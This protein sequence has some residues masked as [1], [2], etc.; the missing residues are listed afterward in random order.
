MTYLK[1]KPFV[2]LFF[3]LLC[4]ASSGFTQDIITTQNGDEIACKVLEID[5]PKIKYRLS[6][7]PDGPIRTILVADVFMIK[8]ADGTK[9]LFKEPINKNKRN[10]TSE[11]RFRPFTVGL[12]LHMGIEFAAPYPGAMLSLS[13]E[14]PEV[15]VRFALDGTV[16]SRTFSPYYLDIFTTANLNFHYVFKLSNNKVE[17]FPELGV[18]VWAGSYANLA[19]VNVGVGFDYR[20]SDL[21]SIYVHPRYHIIPSSSVGLFF[22]NVGAR[23]RFGKTG[24]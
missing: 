13:Y 16:T 4:T 20:V 5:P 24:K 3:L 8:Y 22:F 18:G 1:H 14:I 7:Q 19:T 6:S 10:S 17:I 11:R 15:N 21:F 9:E 2:F 23:I 12:G